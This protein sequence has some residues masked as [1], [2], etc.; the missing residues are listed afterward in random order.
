MNAHAVYAVNAVIFHPL[1]RAHALLS[2]KIRECLWKGMA[3]QCIHCIQC[4]ELSRGTTTTIR[5]MQIRPA[6]AGRGR[7]TTPALQS[8]PAR[9]AIALEL[10]PE[11]EAEAKKRQAHGETAPGR[12]LTPAMGE[13][14]KNRK[15]EA[16]DAAAKMVGVSGTSVQQANAPPSPLTPQSR[17]HCVSVRRQP[18]RNLSCVLECSGPADQRLTLA[19]IPYSQ[20]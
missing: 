14:L 15:S 2:I 12:T 1:L 18:Y 3:D 9:A 6:A 16:V 7:A 8:R 13:A 10:L 11:L 17:P 20:T 5:T 4:S 19:D